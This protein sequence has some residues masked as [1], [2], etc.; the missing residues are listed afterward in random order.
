MRLCGASQHPW[1]LQWSQTCARVFK[2]VSPTGFMALCRFSLFGGSHA[3]FWKSRATHTYQPITH[4]P[5]STR[6]KHARTNKQT[7][8]HTHT[9]THRNARTN[10]RTHARHPS[11]HSRVSKRNGGPL[12]PWL[13]A[14]KICRPL[15]DKLLVVDLAGCLFWCARVSLAKVRFRV[16]DLGIGV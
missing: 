15:G 7:N 10:E 4:L 8:K 13:L 11:C 2:V 16:L 14:R 6:V 3:P 1:D 9:H 12:I 5:A